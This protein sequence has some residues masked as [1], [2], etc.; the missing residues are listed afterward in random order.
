MTEFKTNCGKPMESLAAPSMV[1]SLAE[2]E[3]PERLK[4]EPTRQYESLKY[5][6]MI[7]MWL[8]A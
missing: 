8:L 2:E 7:N 1:A 6:L 3:E 4:L 5:A